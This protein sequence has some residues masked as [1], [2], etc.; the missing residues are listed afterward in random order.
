[1][2]KIFLTLVSILLFIPVMVNAAECDTSK[3]YIDSISIDQDKLK[4]NVIELEEAI[5]KEKENIKFA[6]NNDCKGE[7]A[8]C[9][10]ETD[11]VSL[12]DIINSKETGHYLV[13]NYDC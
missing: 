4:G 12:D 11:I 1:M 3:V 9:L 13:G 2:K 10:F 5:A 8:E 7:E 6:Y